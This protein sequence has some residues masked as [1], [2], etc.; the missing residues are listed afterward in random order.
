MRVRTLRLDTKYFLRESMADSDL[1]S[2]HSLRLPA[3]KKQGIAH[4]GRQFSL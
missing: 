2:S 1:G 3:G 4:V